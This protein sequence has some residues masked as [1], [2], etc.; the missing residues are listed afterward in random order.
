MFKSREIIFQNCDLKQKLLF[1]SIPKEVLSGRKAKI[2]N[3][4]A[5]RFIQACVSEKGGE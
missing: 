1:E 5:L 3:D 4:V 2:T